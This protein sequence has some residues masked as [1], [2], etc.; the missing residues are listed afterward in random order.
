M[1]EG[2]SMDG[3][4]LLKIMTGIF[5][6]LF[7][8]AFTACLLCGCTKNYKSVDEYAAEMAKVRGSYPAYT[9]DMSMVEN[10]TNTKI[11]TYTK[12]NKWKADTSVS[13]LGG[14]STMLY[15]GKD[16]VVYTSLSKEALIT[17]IREAGL[18]DSDVNMAASLM[19]PAALLIN[20][21]GEGYNSSM[22]SDAGKQNETSDSESKIDAFSIKGVFTDKKEKAVKNGYDCR[23][24]KFDNPAI[25]REVCVNDKLGIAV[26]SSIKFGKY[27]RVFTLN[28]VSTDDI[29]DSVFN[30][31]NGMKKMTMDEYM[32]K[33][34]AKLD[35]LQR[36]MKKNQRK[37]MRSLDRYNY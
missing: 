13:G 30:L 19:N 11:K 26:S 14:S 16:V 4:T 15:D 23:L 36:K 12:G 24:I 5:I 35:K 31:P 3:R 33:Q 25:K 28:S 37:S 34:Q 32:K 1:I 7:V 6:S 22:F 17:P 18:T 29:D 20:W 10:G 21:S 8:I 9:I 2:V 27:D